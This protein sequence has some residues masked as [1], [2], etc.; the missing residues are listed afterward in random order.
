MVMER[1]ILFLP[2]LNFRTCIIKV[3]DEGILVYP[4]PT[5]GTFEI[6]FSTP[7]EYFTIEIIS[8]T[9]KQLYRKEFADYAGRTFRV[10]ELLHLD[11]GVYFVRIINGTRIKV[12]KII[13]HKKD[14][15]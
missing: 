5:S 15:D 3:P 6:I 13:K 7:P 11:Q 1:L 12:R 8:L 2:W 10:T 9:G 14:H 4:N